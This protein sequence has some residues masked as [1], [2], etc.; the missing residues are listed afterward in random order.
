[1]EHYSRQCPRCATSFV[2][3][4]D[5]G[6]CPNCGLFSR[7]GRDGE[8]V[9][10]L[11]RGYFDELSDDDPHAHGPLA[12]LFETLECGGGPIVTTER[13]DGAPSVTVVRR[14]LRQHFK[15]LQQQLREEFSDIRFETISEPA[16]HPDWVGT[17]FSDCVRLYVA[18][19]HSEGQRFD[20]VCAMTS[21]GGAIHVLPPDADYHLLPHD[22][23]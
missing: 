7:V 5:R 11:H 17:E 21:E 12:S 14:Q 13:Y 18:S 6:V 20:I 8:I 23:S 4:S 22:P 19:W 16:S 15:W 10:L 9:V 3:I 2:A 1:M